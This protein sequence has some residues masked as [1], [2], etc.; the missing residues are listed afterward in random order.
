MYLLNPWK[1]FEIQKMKTTL[2]MRNYLTKQIYL[3]R[4]K[5]EDYKDN[6]NTGMNHLSLQCKTIYDIDLELAVLLKIKGE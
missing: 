2:T 1:I 4:N 3:F 5:M 6:L